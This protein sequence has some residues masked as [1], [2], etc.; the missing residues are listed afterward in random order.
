MEIPA[1][2]VVVRPS[3]GIPELDA[4]DVDAL[5]SAVTADDRSERR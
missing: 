1:Y 2:N 3:P 5:R 4:L